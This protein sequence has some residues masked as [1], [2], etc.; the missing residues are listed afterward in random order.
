M[1]KNKEFCSITTSTI[2]GFTLLEVLISLSILLIAIIPLSLIAYKNTDST[3][4]EKEIIAN[5]LIEQES[6]L[7]RAYPDQILPVKRRT[8][9]GTEWLI[10]TEYTG[11]DLVQYK[12]RVKDH[13]LRSEFTFY[14]RRKSEK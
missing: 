7:V 6:A 11:T 8:V 4:A 3:D 2:S 5:C 10:Q 12:M 13:K 1:Q 14:G 9:L